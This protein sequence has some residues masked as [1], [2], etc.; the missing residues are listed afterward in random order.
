MLGQA[1]REGTA[2]DFSF[3]K[4]TAKLMLVGGAFSYSIMI[5]YC[6]EHLLLCGTR[7]KQ[8]LHIYIYMY[9]LGKSALG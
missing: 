2:T 9:I 5:L 7:R 6:L 8:R 4:C 3:K 1:L